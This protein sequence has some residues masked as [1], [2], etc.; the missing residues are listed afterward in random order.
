MFEPPDQDRVAQHAA[1]LIHRTKP[2][3]QGRM[4]TSTGISGRAAKPSG[5]ALIL[6]DDAELQRRGGQRSPICWAVGF[7]AVGNHRQ[8]VDIEAGL[9]RT[10]A[11][12]TSIRSEGDA[13]IHPASKD[14]LV[15]AEQLP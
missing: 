1:D 12:F 14:A 6:G 5:T 4:R 8:S 9:R 2:R 7:Q 11:W 13:M 3:P 10:R 15:T